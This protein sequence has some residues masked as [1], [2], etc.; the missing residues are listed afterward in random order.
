MMI[1]ETDKCTGCAACMNICPTGSI[2]MEEDQYGV[3]YPV[4]DSSTCISCKKCTR[5]CPVNNEIPFFPARKVYASWRKDTQRLKDSASGGIGAVLAEHWISDGGIVCGTEYDEN[6]HPHIQMETTL[7]GIE[8]FKGSKYVQSATGYIYSEVRGLLAQ[9]KKILFFG[10]PCQLA[11]LYSVV[12]R[13]LENLVT[14][15]ILCHGVSPDRYFQDE[16]E[17][18]KKETGIKEFDNVGFRTNRWLLD[19]CFTLWNK[20]QLVYEKPAYE[21]RYFA[22]FLTGLSLRES[23]YQCKYKSTKRLG[24]LLIGDFIGLGN[25]IPFADSPDHKSL[26]ICMTEKGSDLLQRCSDDLVVIERTMEEAVIEGRSLRE[27]FPR[28]ARQKEFRNRVAEKGFLFAAEEILGEDIAKASKTNPKWRMT[29][30][31]KI[32]LYY[33]F[34]IKI[35][36]RRIYREK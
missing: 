30:K 5:T 33:K 13:S 21:N 14:V 11:G 24:D 8:K 26:V 25:R 9:G 31:F 27:P 35:Y 3:L 16:L 23:C 1:C 18:L 29:R 2:S 7:K 28:H 12:G 32:W 15:E 36:N 20:G 6:F 22:S 19:F 17:Q 34:H 4:I 10:T